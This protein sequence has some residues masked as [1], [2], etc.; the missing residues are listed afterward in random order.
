MVKIQDTFCPAMGPPLHGYPSRW[1]LYLLPLRSLSPPRPPLQALLLESPSSATPQSSPLPLF[2]RPHPQP[3]Q[4]H[5]L[6]DSISTCSITC[7]RRTRPGDLRLFS[8]FSLWSGSLSLTH[9]LMALLLFQSKT[10]LRSSGC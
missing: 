3:Q 8:I 2:L 9:L 10:P 4:P 5:A 6:Q 7:P 1:Q